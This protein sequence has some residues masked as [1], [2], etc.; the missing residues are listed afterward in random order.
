MLK[1]ITGSGNHARLYISI[2]KELFMP[3]YNMRPHEYDKG[4]AVDVYVGKTVFARRSES[5]CNASM[6]MNVI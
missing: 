4:L 6:K 3:L 1:W 2:L 5:D